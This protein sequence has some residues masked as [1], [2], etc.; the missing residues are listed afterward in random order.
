MREGM[1]EGMR[2]GVRKEVRAAEGEEGEESLQ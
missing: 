2:K 1:R